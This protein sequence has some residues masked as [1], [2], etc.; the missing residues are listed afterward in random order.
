MYFLENV[1]PPVQLLSRLIHKHKLLE[2]SFS[3]GTRKEPGLEIHKN[4][5]KS[6][7]MIFCY[8]YLSL[9]LC[10]EKHSSVHLV[11]FFSFFFDKQHRKLS[12]PSLTSTFYSVVGVGHIVQRQGLRFVSSVALNKMAKILR[13]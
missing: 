11:S 3:M 13:R 12:P 2:I 10:L 9:A 5:D 6:I 4:V 8:V 1:S 7:S